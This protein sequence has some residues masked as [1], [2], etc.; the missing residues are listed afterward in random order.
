MPDLGL[1]PAEIFDH[2]LDYLAP[3]DAHAARI[4]KSKR[5][6]GFS[7]EKRILNACSLV[8]RTWHLR[9][10]KRLYSSFVWAEQVYSK[11]KLLLFL[12]AVAKN[13]SL[14]NHVKLLDLSLVKD[15]SK[16]PGPLAV[17]G[18]PSPRNGRRM[19]QTQELRPWIDGMNFQIKT[20]TQAIST[21]SLDPFMA[22]LIA[23]LPNVKDFYLELG[24]DGASLSYHLLDILQQPAA[25]Q[26]IEKL[27]LRGHGPFSAGNLFLTRSCLGNAL[28]VALPCLRTLVLDELFY[29]PIPDLSLLGPSHGS[30]ITNL[31][32]RF[33]GCVSRFDNPRWQGISKFLR[34]PKHL[35]SLSLGLSCWSISML[36][37]SPISMIDYG[38]LAELVDLHR[39]NLEY[40]D[41]CD[42][43]D[44]RPMNLNG[45]KKFLDALRASHKLKKLRI[46]AGLFYKQINN[47]RYLPYP[48]ESMLQPSLRALSL[49]G[50][51][52]E[53]EYLE[54]QLIGLI[55]H[56][57]KIGLRFLTLQEGEYDIL[58]W[59]FE[60]SPVVQA[61]LDN[62]INLT[63]YTAGETWADRI[64]SGGVF[65]CD[66]HNHPHEN[67]KIRICRGNTGFLRVG[68][69]NGLQWENYRGK[70]YRDRAAYIEG[71]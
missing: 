10:V 34:Y 52:E 12:W 1:L 26:K 32:I 58:I 48:M 23:C 51:R 3:Q 28:G 36:R 31:A 2:V 27:V 15:F 43:Q 53:F 42:H 55:K 5:Y 41:I 24:E 57:S 11:H 45:K 14:A 9:T 49:Y 16:K 33:H 61:C 38:D 67:W 54:N 47:L 20:I 21:G 13:A 30:S 22:I 65:V 62:R 59:R 40:L 17:R 25:L 7:H 44:L 63:A 46:S 29:G 60:N 18:S 37:S 64:S 39:E 8:N 6:N 56:G 4:V 50:C 35:S 70:L 69:N 68:P 66:G 19:L 71:Y